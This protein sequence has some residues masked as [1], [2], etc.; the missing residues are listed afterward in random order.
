MNKPA[1]T[2]PPAPPPV[3]RPEAFRDLLTS[4]GLG[5]IT[6]G[7]EAYVRARGSARSVRLCTFDGRLPSLAAAPL[8]D[9]PTAFLAC[10]AD[11]PA[12]SDWELKLLT[13]FSGAAPFLSGALAAERVLKVSALAVMA[14][15]SAL[16]DKLVRDQGGSAAAALVAADV[17]HELV[18]N[19]LLDAPV[20]PDGAPRYAYHRPSAPIDP[21]DACRV[22]FRVEGTHLL[23]SAIDR[24]G[25]LERAPVASALQRIGRSARLEV[26]G[27]GAGLGLLRILQHSDLVAFRVEPRTRTEVLCAVD[28]GPDRRRTAAL[29]SL[30]LT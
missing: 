5:L 7:G 23:V 20:G 3:P 12:P 4:C 18:A 15:A 13:A 24:F 8:P 27:G 11:G 30:F 14:E 1:Q 10:R 17:T 19:A 21:E 9:G 16:A 6:T 25:R 2:V 28:L 29:K 26:S 22:G